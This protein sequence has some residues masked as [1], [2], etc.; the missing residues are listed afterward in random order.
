MARLAREHRTSTGGTGR[1][2]R[3][4][5]GAAPGTTRA[6][7]PGPRK[8]ELF[9]LW[10]A[11][12]FSLI[13]KKERVLEVHRQVLICSVNI[14]PTLQTFRVISIGSGREQRSARRA[15]PDASGRLRTSPDATG[16]LRTP[17]DATGRLRTPPDVSGRLPSPSAMAET[18][19]LESP[20]GFIVKLSRVAER[21]AP[22]RQS[23]RMGGP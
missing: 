3:A 9:N 19:Q 12:T 1:V 8:A 20:D 21:A 16:R 6:D 11:K 2:A 18:M 5:G 17:Q 14:G 23:I 4:D 15:P 10:A 22:S 7:P 13:K